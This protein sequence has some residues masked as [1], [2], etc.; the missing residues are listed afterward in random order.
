MKQL[1]FMLLGA[2]T[3]ISSCKKDDDP[4][5]E[6]PDPKPKAT[7]YFPLKKGNYW[8]Y[9]VSEVDTN[10]VWVK[11]L[12]TDSIMVSGTTVLNGDT[13]YILKGT[14]FLHPEYEE[15]VRDSAG[16]MVTNEGDQQFTAVN[17]K[18]TLL[19]HEVKYNDSLLFAKWSIRMEEVKGSITTSAGVF[20]DVIDRKM[21]VEQGNMRL[22][23]AHRYP[24]INHQYYARGVGMIY[25]EY[26]Y[27]GSLHSIRV[28][29]TK[30]HIED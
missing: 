30:Y 23:G 2:L 17:F 27:F 4:P 19:Q 13:F 9:E 6:K 1:L 21:T 20:G 5:E 29:L 8:V 15:L 24:R 18:D 3:I 12:H 11:N 14:T 26:F 10:G 7:D 22:V 25:D 16:S 28:E